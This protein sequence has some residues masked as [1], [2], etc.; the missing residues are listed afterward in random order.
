VF[1]RQHELAKEL[2]RPVSVHCV[3]ALGDLLEILKQTGPLPAGVFLHS[4]LG[5][6]EMVSVVTNLGCYFSLS[7]FL[8]GM[9]STKA[10][11][12]LNS[13]PSD[14]IPLETAG[15]NALPKLDDV[16]VSLVPVHSS[17]ADN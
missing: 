8:T 13:I 9:K 6:A 7:G 14:R 4:Y 1:R 10:K 16:S 17:D 15:P 3:R 11:Q 5:S 2:E 12:M